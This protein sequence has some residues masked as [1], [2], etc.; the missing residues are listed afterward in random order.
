MSASNI[1]MVQMLHNGTPILGRDNNF[2]LAYSTEHCDGSCEFDLSTADFLQVWWKVEDRS[3]TCPQIQ[4][5]DGDYVCR[6]TATTAGEDAD[7]TSEEISVIT[8]CK[9]S[10]ACP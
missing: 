10:Y 4:S 5:Y 8:Y 9:Y 6:G 1:G 3:L 7:V 2:E